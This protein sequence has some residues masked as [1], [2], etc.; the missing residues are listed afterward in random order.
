[1]ICVLSIVQSDKETNFEMLKDKFVLF[2]KFAKR[3]NC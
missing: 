2:A 1:L 3:L